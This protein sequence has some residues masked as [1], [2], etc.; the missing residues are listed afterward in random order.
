MCCINIHLTACLPFTFNKYSIKLYN[1]LYIEHDCYKR[2]KENVVHQSVFFGTN[3]TDLLK[4]LHIVESSY[5][6]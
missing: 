5:V 6:K 1:L 3:F 2:S 4:I